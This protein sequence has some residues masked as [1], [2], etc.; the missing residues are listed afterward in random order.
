MS[1]QSG[2]SVMT[3]RI[4]GQISYT[5]E[6]ELEAVKEAIERIYR[7]Y[8][9]LGYGTHFEAPKQQRDGSWR[10]FGYRSSS[11]D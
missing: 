10:A 3:E 11:C 6:G 4:G 1:E 9:P 5:V 7:N 2:A 8:H